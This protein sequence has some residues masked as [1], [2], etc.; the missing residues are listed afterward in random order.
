MILFDTDICIEL[1][2]G[3]KKII[4]KRNNY[5]GNIAISFMTVAELY[6]GAEN[7]TRIE[8]NTGLIESFFLTIQIIQTDNLI[9]KKFG[10]L[11]TYLKK[12]NLTLPDADIFI[13]ATTLIKCEKLITGNLKHFTHFEVLKIDNWAK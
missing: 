9:L 8:E 5:N 4:G 7:S 13:A 1:L 10:E 12:E 3:N 11:K 2:R 6:F